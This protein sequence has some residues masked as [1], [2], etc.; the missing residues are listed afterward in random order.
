MDLIG[1]A[2]EI[3]AVAQLAIVPFAAPGGSAGINSSLYLNVSQW[4]NAQLCAPGSD[5]AGAIMFHGT[6]TL[7]ETVSGVSHLAQLGT[8]KRE[9]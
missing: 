6:N 7:A 2:S 1:N 5:I 8:T 3:L 4:A 9:V